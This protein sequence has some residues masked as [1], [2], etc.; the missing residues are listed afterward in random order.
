MLDKEPLDKEQAASF[1][2]V[3]VR[4]I[5]RYAKAGKLIPSYQD[6]SNGGRKA[7]FDQQQLETLK[8]EMSQ[9]K[10][11]EPA[12]DDHSQKKSLV[13]LSSSPGVVERIATLLENNSNKTFVPIESKLTLSLAQAVELSGLSRNWLLQAIKLNELKA[14]KRGK[15]WNIKRTD[16][17]MYVESM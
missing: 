13:T 10:T 11:L 4:A 12:K 7:F 8:T 6:K 16:L 17:E 5:E 14:I 9:P 15:G 2:G 3:S 1:L